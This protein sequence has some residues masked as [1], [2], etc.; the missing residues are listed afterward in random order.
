MSESSS[1]EPHS[2]RYI[3]VPKDVQ[4]I[5]TPFNGNPLELRE[6]IQNVEATYEVVD[7]SD[8]SLLLFM[9]GTNFVECIDLVISLI[10]FT[11]FI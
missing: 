9:Q 11:C 4:L 7:P 3:S 10:H 1:D 8:Y 2:T 6:F 5:P